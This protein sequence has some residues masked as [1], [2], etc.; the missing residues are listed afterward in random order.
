M[1]T[2][3]L[4]IMGGLAA[5]AWYFFTKMHPAAGPTGPTPV[6]TCQQR[7]PNWTLATC[8]SRLAQYETAIPQVKAQLAAILAPRAG[9]LAAGDAA[10]VQAI[11]KAAWPWQQAL[12]GHIQD[13][14]NLTGINLA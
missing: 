13:Y 1:K 11:D 7:K 10:A 4:L 14:W 2:Q 3:E 8:Q 12:Q 9:Y 6:D 5:G